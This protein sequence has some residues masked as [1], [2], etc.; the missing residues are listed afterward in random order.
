MDKTVEFRGWSDWHVVKRRKKTIG[1]REKK[2]NPG[3]WFKLGPSN[4]KRFMMAFLK[5]AE[6]I[7]ILADHEKRRR[8]SQRLFCSFD[9]GSIGSRS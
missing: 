3:D 8:M 2:R 9:H 1:S 4:L 7:S 5:N 6:M